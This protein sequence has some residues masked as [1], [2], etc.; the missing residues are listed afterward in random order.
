MLPIWRYDVVER[1][2][3]R[4][5]SNDPGPVYVVQEASSLAA[6]HSCCKIIYFRPLATL[7]RAKIALPPF[8]DNASDQA[9]GAL[10][11]GG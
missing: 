9:L 11:Y 1:W 5:N 6:L 3:S 10:Q 2:Y 4:D 7:A 8:G